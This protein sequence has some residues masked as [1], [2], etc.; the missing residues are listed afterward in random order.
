MEHVPGDDEAFQ[1]QSFPLNQPQR[2]FA[3]PVQHTTTRFPVFVRDTGVQFPSEP[4]VSSPNVVSPPGTVV[5]LSGANEAPPG[6][7]VA[8]PAFPPSLLSWFKDRVPNI[9]VPNSLMFLYTHPPSDDGWISQAGLSTKCS[10][11][12]RHQQQQQRRQSQVLSS[13]LSLTELRNHYLL[14]P[15]YQYPMTYR[16]NIW[17]LALNLPKSQV[18]F[19][20][21]IEECQS[22]QSDPKLQIDLPL[23]NPLM[24]RRLE[25]LLKYIGVWCVELMEVK[26]SFRNCILHY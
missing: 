23:N 2:S 25:T 1:T 10:G 6:P 11:G 24:K 14:S 3:V 12:L 21:L 13:V 26:V 8:R 19:N 9:L 20:T 4:N 18:A 22:R 15:P 17:E 16:Q 7:N 5:N